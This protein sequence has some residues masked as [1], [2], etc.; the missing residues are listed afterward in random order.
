[1]HPASRSRLSATKA[2]RAAAACRPCRG[3]APG[4][5]HFRAARPKHD[6]GAGRASAIRCRAMPAHRK[7]YLAEWLALL[8]ALALAAALIG[9]EL[10]RRHASVGDN[11]RDRIAVQARV[12]DENLSQQLGGINKALLSIRA[13]YAQSSG[14]RAGSGSARL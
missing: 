4:A 11:E 1:M 5:V 12:I 2:T 14:E 3:V 9:F 7:R 6:A 10:Q 13:E 8:L